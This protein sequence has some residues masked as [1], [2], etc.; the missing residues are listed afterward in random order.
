MMH[1]LIADDHAIVRE[2]LKQILLEINPD[3]TIVEVSTGEEAFNLIKS[4]TYHLIILDVSMPGMT[5]LDILKAMNERNISAP[6]LVLS[7][8]PQE[9]YAI[10]AMRL[11]ASGYLSKDSAY[12]ELGAAVQKVLS[13]GKYISSVIAEKL[14]LSFEGEEEKQKH[15]LLSER[16]FQIMCLL[17]RGLTVT[18]VGKQLFISEKT[19]ST[20]RTRLLEK[21]GLKRNADLTL[22]AIRKN[23]IS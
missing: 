8:H 9:Q 2:G 17:A 3:S 12:E 23:L 7:M 18:E 11:G 6:V 1:I 4:S 21:M 10:R 5:G 15:E 14:A 19:V 16:E 22:Y 20:H 13:G